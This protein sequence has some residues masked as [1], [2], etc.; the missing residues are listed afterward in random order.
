MFGEQQGEQRVWLS[1]MSEGERERR[2]EER[3]L[4][5]GQCQTTQGFVGCGKDLGFYSK[6]SRKPW[7]VI[8]GVVMWLEFQW[9]EHQEA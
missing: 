1:F 2:G 3:R 6:R 7:S 8:N 4:A 5:R 9:R